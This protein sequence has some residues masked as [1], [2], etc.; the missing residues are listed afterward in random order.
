MIII[1]YRVLYR[2]RQIKSIHYIYTF[3]TLGDKK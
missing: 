1:I 2:I 3:N